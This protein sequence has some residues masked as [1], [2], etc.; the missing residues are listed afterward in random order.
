MESSP[1]KQKI[2]I[3]G[4]G[5]SGIKC[6]Y[7]LFKSGKYEIVVLESADYIGG[8]MKHFKF[9]DRI[10]EAGANWITHI[11]HKNSEKYQN[12]NP[13]W[14]LAKKADLTSYRSDNFG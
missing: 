14:T 2:I 5:A 6:A 7:D 13:I 4:A 1:N 3:I 10:F 12:E 8:R 9:N 11:R